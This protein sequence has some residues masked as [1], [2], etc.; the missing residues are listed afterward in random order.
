MSNCAM[1]N[2]GGTSDFGVKE[3]AQR[4]Q[5]EVQSMKGTERSILA[6]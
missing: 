4:L 3:R 5:S 1:R 2:A 6:Q